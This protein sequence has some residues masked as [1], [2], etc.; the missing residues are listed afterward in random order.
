MKVLRYP[1][2]ERE[3]EVKNI[4][5]CDLTRVKG[6]PIIIYIPTRDKYRFVI[7]EVINKK[8]SESRDKVWKNMETFIPVERWW[9]DD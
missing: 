2:S 3:I 8:E 4:N 5:V 6:E 9:F 1:Y 7:F